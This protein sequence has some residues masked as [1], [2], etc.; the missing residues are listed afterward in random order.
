[1]AMLLSLRGFGFVTFV[2]QESVTKVLSSGPHMI[3]G[4]KVSC[5]HHKEDVNPP[6]ALLFRLIQSL[7]LTNHRPQ[8]R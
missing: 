4:K 7:L 3:D 5:F 2:G 8:G 6:V 1:M